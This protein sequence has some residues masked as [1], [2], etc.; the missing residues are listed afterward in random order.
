MAGHTGSR[1]GA[2][3]CGGGK[4]RSRSRRRPCAGRPGTAALAAAAAVLAASA[5]AAAA[6]AGTAAPCAP[7]ECLWGLPAAAAAATENGTAAETHVHLPARDL[8]GGAALAGFAPGAAASNATHMFVADA[9]GG[10]ILVFEAADGSAPRRTA[11]LAVS[12]SPYGVAVNDSGHVFA[13]DPAAGRVVVLAPNGSLAGELL[14]AAAAGGGSDPA[15]PMDWP[16]GLAAGPDGRTYV[17]ERNAGRVLVFG[18]SGEQIG[19]IGTG[20][21]GRLLA[22]SDVAVNG[23]GHVLVA[24]TAAN[25][26]QAFDAGGS[27]AGT[28][29]VPSLD[30][31]AG[32]PHGVAA[33]GGTLYIASLVQGAVHMHSGSGWSA[34][35]ARLW[36]SQAAGG[37]GGGDGDAPAPAPPPQHQ[38]R[39]RPLSVAAG[40]GGMLLVSDGANA[41]A[42]LFAPD[43]TL[44]YAL[45]GSE[46]GAPPRPG[47]DAPLR[48][49]DAA[50]A[51]AAAGSGAG[52]GTLYI[53][54]AG[55]GAAAV[56][57]YSFDPASGSYGRLWTA[58]GGDGGG[59]GTGHGPS[60]PAGI[61]VDASGRVLVAD[62][63]GRGGAP[64]VRIL[65]PGDGSQ[66]GAL[67][68]G[69]P[70]SRPAG[71][72]AGP[73]G[74]IAVADPPAGAV[75]LLAA[76]GTEAGLIGGLDDPVDVAFMSD[77][78]V[79]VAE[80]GSHRVRVFDP[81]A[82][83]GNGGGGGG[84]G[85]G[86]GGG[87]GGNGGG[88]G[89]GQ[90]GMPAHGGRSAA[91]V[92]SFGLGPGGVFLPEAV[93][94]DAGDRILVADSGGEAHGGRR[95]QVFDYAGRL[96]S[97]FGASGEPG[98]ARPQGGLVPGAGMPYSPAG[99]GV[100]P[101]GTVLVSDPAAGPPG[102]G[103]VRVFEALDSQPPSVVSFGMAGGGPGYAP[104]AAGSAAGPYSSIAANVT[105]SEPVVVRPPAQPQRPPSLALGLDANRSSA[106]A[107]D[108]FCGGGPD[109]APGLALYESGSGTASLLFGYTVLEG[110]H[111]AA[112]DHASTRPIDARGSSITD[113]AGNRAGLEMPAAPG[114]PG[115]FSASVR[116]PVNGSAGAFVDVGLLVANASS[117]GARAAGLAACELNRGLAAPAASP[118]ASPAAGP[119]LRLAAVE[120]PAASAA[121]LAGA[122]VP[123]GTAA[124]P[125]LQALRGAHDSGRGPSLYVTTLPDAALATPTGISRSSSAAGYALGEGLL[126]AAA[127]SSAPSL[128][129]GN[130]TLHRLV[131]ADD[132][133]AYALARE[134]GPEIDVLFPII[135]SDMYGEPAASRQG[136]APFAHGLYGLLLGHLRD[137]GVVVGGVEAGHLN[138][139]RT[140]RAEFN[141]TSPYHGWEAGAARLELEL[142]LLR[143]QVG[144]DRVAVL[145]LGSAA[146]YVRLAEHAAPLPGLSGVRWLAAGDVA[147]S[148]LVEESDAAASLAAS[149]G[150]SALSFDPGTGSAGTAEGRSGGSGGIVGPTAAA[151]RIDRLVGPSLDE[152]VLSYSAYD[153]VQVLGRAVSAA[154][155]ADAAAA[156][157]DAADPNASDAEPAAAAHPP[158]PNAQAVSRH[159]AAAALGHAGA[160][161][162]L[163]L[164]DAGDL[165]MPRTY[166][167]WAM[168]GATGRWARSSLEHGIETCSVGVANQELDFGSVTARAA[169]AAARQTLVNTGSLDLAWVA[170][171]AGDWRVL[172]GS[173]AVLSTL[174]ASLTEYV[175]LSAPAASTAAAA[176]FAPLPDDPA[177]AAT[178]ARGLEPIGEADILL[179]INLRP[180]ESLG[181]SGL[182]Q[183]MSYAASCG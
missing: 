173:G 60:E 1:R 136:A 69:G 38:L 37:D 82:G 143:G 128:S 144:A 88:G 139:D 167:V 156:V 67:P 8:P 142:A 33:A 163:R 97:V 70:G 176:R 71:I 52:A 65:L 182:V 110:D 92:A 72:A 36:H 43:G 75:R 172:D 98:A 77:G 157:P 34:E 81:A 76:N 162:K 50:A 44:R 161:G 100:A 57:A 63:G 10:Q 168:D 158:A 141:F 68:V 137:T 175:D 123:P 2:G 54:Y 23:T 15:S 109:A 3:G 178:V 159:M 152:E 132:H 105:F 104:L 61:A 19:E 29:A 150:L 99:L 113:R 140:K 116:V 17:A 62:R 22:P 170:I 93:A 35:P 39:P 42:A 25:A 125:A 171:E 73:S 41:Q 165:D 32:S 164:D 9:A 101:D 151:L 18:G 64:S 13:S 131:P 111:A 91:D 46:D 7:A 145:Y 87:G 59:G 27:H 74:M 89:G 49:V 90:N 127:A 119:F 166:G 103:A 78:A 179:R 6:L 148:P 126:L 16:A 96:V 55:S 48:P 112:V 31:E 12:G 108:E 177:R 26:V 58:G 102:R 135:Q 56:A 115:S 83:G 155:R 14:P 138:Y 120:A 134:W 121:H 45:A 40:P 5:V 154:A 181:G 85:N 122:P 94:V 118:A 86:G 53:S 79:V 169:S 24:D 107:S 66:A 4:H 124:W 20:G 106:A 130:D 51:A 180:V 153:A 183:S 146:E 11:A 117:A 47:G 149:T 133:L 28:I 129:A 84:G 95:V 21:P 160:L 30:G 114:A 147:R 80:R 174:P